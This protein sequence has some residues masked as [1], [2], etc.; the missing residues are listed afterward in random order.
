MSQQQHP[1][2]AP[3]T[4]GHTPGAAID[5]RTIDDLRQRLFAAID[6]VRDGS[7]ALD[8]AR[9]IGELSQ[10]IVNTAKVEVDYLRTAEPDNARSKFL[11]GAEVDALPNGITT[12]TRHRLQG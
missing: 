5:S 6:G 7:L 8:K 4:N 1:A 10:V 9:L 3:A 2:A 12:I 11:D